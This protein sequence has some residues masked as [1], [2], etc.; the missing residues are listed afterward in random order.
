[1]LLATQFELPIFSANYILINF[2]PDPADPD[3]GLPSPGRGAHLE[4][5]VSI[6][7]GHG[8]GVWKRIE[9]ERCRLEE[10]RAEDELL[11]EW[12]HPSG[13]YP[14]LTHSGLPGL[15]P[16]LTG[17]LLRTYPDRSSS[18]PRIQRTPP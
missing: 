11:R 2:L 10:R 5:K 8:H 7:D 13:V 18:L 17:M 1:V 3:P 9:A 14:E 16:P 6:N 12:N 4:L 15:D